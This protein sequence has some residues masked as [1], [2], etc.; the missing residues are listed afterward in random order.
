MAIV[1][2]G[3]GESDEHYQA[4]KD[5]AEEREEQRRKEREDAKQK[6]AAEKL[7]RQQAREE[8]RLARIE[9]RQG[10]RSERV[11]T[12]QSGRAAR[13]AERQEQQTERTEIKADAG[14]YDEGPAEAAA[15]MTKDIT[16]GG[17]AVASKAVEGIAAVKTMVGGGVDSLAGNAAGSAAEAALAKARP[18]IIGGALLLVVGIFYIGRK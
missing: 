16:E 17:V 8:A 14:Y 6:R 12:R 3:L 4:R 18:Y 1:I 11:E 9:A 15:A 2:R 5:A 7:A 10:G 13:T